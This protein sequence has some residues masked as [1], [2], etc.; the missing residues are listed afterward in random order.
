[1]NKKTIVKK[2]IKDGEQWD[3]KIYTESVKISK[4]RDEFEKIAERKRIMGF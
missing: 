3:F 1:M 2:E 4:L